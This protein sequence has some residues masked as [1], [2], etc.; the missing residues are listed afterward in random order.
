M[1]RTN[2]LAASSLLTVSMLPFAALRADPPRGDAT[3]ASW[4]FEDG[5]KGWPADTAHVLADASGNGQNG[6]AVGNPR[7]V[8]IGAG[9]GGPALELVGDAQHGFVPDDSAFELTDSL[10]L[11]AIARIDRYSESPQHLS[12]IVHRGDQRAGL[13]PWFLGILDTG[14]LVFLIADEHNRNAVV[15]SP[16]PAPRGR[17]LHVAGTFDAEAGIL[18]LF[19]DGELV[20]TSDTEIRPFGP[21][22][23]G[24][25]GIGIGNLAAGG[26]QGFRGAIAEIRISRAALQP[27]NFLTAR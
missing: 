7:F 18:R 11:E 6:L 17:A 21:L 23:A 25:A 26:N 13:D 8:R 10:T 4:R 14:Q 19:V 9:P 12:Y 20:A 22:A 1:N 27:E 16:A 5:V 15:R 3:V 2:W 24:G